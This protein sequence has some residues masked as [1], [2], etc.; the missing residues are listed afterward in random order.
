MVQRAFNFGDDGSSALQSPRPPL[1]DSE[2]R[3][4]LDPVGQILYPKELRCAIYFGGIDPSLRC[5]CA[6][7]ICQRNICLILFVMI[8]QESGMEAHFKRLS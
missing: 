7:C 3:K 2:F 6:A 5:V 4:F 1:S 8:A